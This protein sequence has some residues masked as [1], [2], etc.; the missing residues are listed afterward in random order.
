MDWPM[1]VLMYKQIVVTFAEEVERDYLD[2]GQD[3]EFAS[4]K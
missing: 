1:A 2:T 3:A 4:G